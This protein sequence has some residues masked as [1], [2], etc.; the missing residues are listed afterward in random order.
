MAAFSFTAIEKVS[1]GAG[2]GDLNFI[3]KGREGPFGSYPFL[4][5]SPQPVNV[6]PDI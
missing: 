5:S 6:G 3:R 1:L 2:G 4:K